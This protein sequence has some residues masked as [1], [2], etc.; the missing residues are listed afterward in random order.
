MVHWMVDTVLEHMEDNWPKKK[1]KKRKVVQKKEKGGEKNGKFGEAP[2][3]KGR[4]G[5]WT[6]M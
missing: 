2:K 3:K 6:I 4:E 1:E 5:N